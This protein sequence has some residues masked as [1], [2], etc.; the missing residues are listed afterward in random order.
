MSVGYFR[1]SIS[2]TRLDLERAT[3]FTTSLLYTH[4]CIL[5]LTRIATQGGESRYDGMGYTCP[6]MD[7]R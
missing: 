5:Q 3:N 7:G 4:L 1:L 6:I 2:M